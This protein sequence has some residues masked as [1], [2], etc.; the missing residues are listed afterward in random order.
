MRELNLEA[1]PENLDRVLEFLDKELEELNC[2]RRVSVQ[3]HVSVEEIFVNIANYAY[4]PTV[5]YA[6]VQAEVEPAK[7]RE[8]AVLVMRFIDSGIPFNPLEREDPDITLSGMERQIG[9]LGIYMVKKRMDDVSYE[10]R[11]DKNILTI[12]KKITEDSDTVKSKA[13]GVSRKF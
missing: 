11:D 13:A 4:N 5:G 2:P 9:G 7:D 8:P 1:R 3:L 10:R 12:R 6:R